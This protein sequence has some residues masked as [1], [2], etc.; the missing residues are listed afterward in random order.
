VP[1]EKK[2]KSE[3]LHWIFQRNVHPWP[4]VRLKLGGKLK[5]SPINATGTKRSGS[6]RAFCIA[7]L[8]EDV[9]RPLLSDLRG[10]NGRKNIIHTYERA[11]AGFSTILVPPS[12][13]L[14][15]SKK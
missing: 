7:D 3:R 11:A 8:R 1:Y 12:K 13:V 9:V 2:K 10:E 6:E 5:N 15:G 14:K 4:D